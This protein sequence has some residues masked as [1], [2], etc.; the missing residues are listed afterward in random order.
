MGFRGSEDLWWEGKG[1]WEF[2]GERGGGWLLCI[3]RCL[4]LGGSIVLM[5]WDGVD[6]KDLQL[7]LG[8]RGM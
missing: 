7:I 2:R 4:T 1:G 5:I 8:E 3:L 6:R